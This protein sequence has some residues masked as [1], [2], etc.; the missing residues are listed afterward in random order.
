MLTAR[1]THC[2]P[3]SDAWST[4]LD[5]SQNRVEGAGPSYVAVLVPHLPRNQAEQI[6][7]RPITPE[8]HAG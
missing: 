5:F 6:A 3:L 2:I 1:T 4:L 8:T 7:F